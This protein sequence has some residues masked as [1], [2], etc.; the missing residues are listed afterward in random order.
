MARTN[1]LNNPA[2]ANNLNGYFGP[3]GTARITNITGMPRATGI[4]IPVLGGLAFPRR[5]VTPAASYEFSVYVKAVGGAVTVAAGANWYTAGGY[6][7][8]TQLAASQALASGQVL[9]ITGVGVAP[10]TADEVLLNVQVEAIAAGAT[11]QVSCGLYED[12]N[13]VGTYFDGGSGAGYAWT[14]TAGNSTSTGPD[15]AVITEAAIKFGWGTADP[16]WS[17]EFAYT[18]APDPVKWENAPVAGMPGHNGNGRRIA[19]CTT[20]TGGYMRLQGLA[21]GDSA[22]CRSRQATQ[23]GRWEVRSRSFNVGASGAIYHFL[24]IIWPSSFLPSPDWPQYGEYDW[25]ETENPSQNFARAYIHYPHPNLP[26]EQEI[27]TLA[28][29]DQTVFHNYA[30][31]W[32]AD[33]VKGFI[34]G[35]E[36][37][38][39]SGGAGP[40]G[41][42]RIQDMPSGHYVTQMDNFDGTTQRAA[43]AQIEWFRFYPL[44]GGGPGPVT[45]PAKNSRGLLP[46]LLG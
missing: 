37:F 39:H 1:F 33:H 38:S 20:V 31:E 30:F 45:D 21:N 36:W 10:A 18:G 4:S 7:S 42:G 8:Y 24:H 17:D 16:T 32:T 15:E 14:G 9:R 6:L 19:S 41:R 25:L 46:V 29:V 28:G 13:A 12:G 2:A 43:E 11:L 40:N 5:A 22:W 3:T 44:S 23:Y 35:N 34:D 27:T 26:V